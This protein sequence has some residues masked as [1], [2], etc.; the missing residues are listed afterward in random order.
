MVGSVLTK[1]TLVAEIGRS[2]YALHKALSFLLLLCCAPY[3]NHVVMCGPAL[4][5]GSL[6]TVL[7][8]RSGKIILIDT[9]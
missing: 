3:D 6:L 7:L 8:L 2:R 9:L 4:L 5:M 1:G